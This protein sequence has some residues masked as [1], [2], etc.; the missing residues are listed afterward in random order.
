MTEARPFIANQL[1]QRTQLRKQGHRSTFQQP[2]QLISILS[3]TLPMD[4]TQTEIQI[5]VQA[6]R[7]KE[8]PVYYD[9]MQ[10]VVSG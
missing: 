4:L 2:R 3:Y 1:S 6:T 5:Y 8:C 7:A 9:N 10:K